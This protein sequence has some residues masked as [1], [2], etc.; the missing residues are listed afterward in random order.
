MVTVRGGDKLENALRDVAARLGGKKTLRVGFLED[1]TYPAG[2]PKALR[3]AYKARKKAGEKGAV[4]GALYGTSV[5]MVAAI[6]NYGAPRA[7]IPPRP[8]FNNMIA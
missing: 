6:Q 3:A 8:F 1:A 5:A 2:K 4:G 7:G